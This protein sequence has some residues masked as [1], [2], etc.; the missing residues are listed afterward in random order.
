MERM[1]IRGDADMR[2]FAQTF[3]ERLVPRDHAIVIAL[4]G[5]LGAGKTT[6]VQGVGSA[7]GIEEVLTSPTFVIMKI[8]ELNHS[9]Q[10]FARLVHI[11]AFRLKGERHLHVL[12]WDALVADPKNL[13]C[14]EWPEQVPG[15]IPSDALR[16]SFAIGEGDERIVSYG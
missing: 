5:E 16:L 6:F 15:L 4:S 14:I 8:Y 2:A 3:T 7:L 11:D 10:G 9:P 12:G 1:H 13:I